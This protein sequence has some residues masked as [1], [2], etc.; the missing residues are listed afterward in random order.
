M[1][2]RAQTPDLVTIGK[3]VFLE[4][5]FGLETSFS[6]SQETCTSSCHFTLGIYTS[7]PRMKVTLMGVA[8]W[9]I[10]KE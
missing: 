1:V 2:K 5:E 10:C 9:Q 3:V 4:Y 6:Y 7:M 8:T